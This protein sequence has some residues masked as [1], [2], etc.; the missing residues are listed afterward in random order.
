MDSKQLA[1][2]RGLIYSDLFSHPLTGVEVWHYAEAVRMTKEECQIAL[3]SLYPLVTE[4]HGYYFLPDRE[5]I[6]ARRENGQRHAEKKIPMAVKL[7]RIVGKIPTVYFIGVSGRLASGSATYADDI[8]FFIITKKNTLFVTRLLILCV[9]QVL[10]KRRKRTE[11]KSWDKV[12]VNM[13]I[14]EQALTFPAEQHNLYVAREIAQLQPMFQRRDT[15]RKFLQRNRWV[16]V[17][18]PQATV[19]RCTFSLATDSLLAQAFSYVLSLFEH[20]AK[21][22]Q[23]RSILSHRTNERVT[24]HLLAFHP[25]DYQARTLRAYTRQVRIYKQLVLRQ[26]RAQTTAP[27]LSADNRN[28]TPMNVV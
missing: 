10:G 6:I 14:D 20:V 25:C 21:Q 22:L 28:V 23:L 8:D 1:V 7:T 16:K 18:L 2:L 24:D 15:Y 4:K 11:R 27:N 9:L 26:K 5:H 17:F 19:K 3:N 13:I 12:C